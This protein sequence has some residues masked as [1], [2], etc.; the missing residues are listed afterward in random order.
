[1]YIPKH[2]TPKECFPSAIAPRHTNQYD[3]RNWRRFSPEILVTADKLRDDYGVMTCNEGSLNGCGFRLPLKEDSNIFYDI[4]G[5]SD[6][7]F[8]RALDLHPKETTSERIRI[9]IVNEKKLSKMV[10]KEYPIP[11]NDRYPFITFL[12]IDITWLHIAYRN[13]YV[14]NNDL[15]SYNP[16]LDCRLE[17]WSPVRGFISLD[18]YLETGDL[19]NE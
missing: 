11:V 3:T 7:Y 6:H 1:M 4:D 12:E 19:K 15:H 5:L 17:L 10:S 18:E 2:F 16:M 8:G 9:D 14:I 13:N